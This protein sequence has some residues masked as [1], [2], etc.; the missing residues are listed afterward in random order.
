MKYLKVY[1]F[2]GRSRGG[3]S[4]FPG[5]SNYGIFNLN[6]NMRSRRCGWYYWGLSSGREVPYRS[7]IHSTWPLPQSEQLGEGDRVIGYPNL[8]SNFLSPYRWLLLTK[9]TDNKMA[10][11]SEFCSLWMSAYWGI[12]QGREQWRIDSERT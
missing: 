9:S 3:L 2:G 5:G 7:Y 4:L 12:E 1:V 6:S 8:S 11:G 10:S